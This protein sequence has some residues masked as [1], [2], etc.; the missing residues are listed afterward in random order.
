MSCSVSENSYY[1]TSII[2][3]KH[4]FSKK[5][6]FWLLFKKQNMHSFIV[7]SFK[8]QSVKGNDVA[9]NREISMFIK[10]NG[11]DLFV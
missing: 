8:S 2:N 5:K 7:A 9:C 1:S 3:G 6:C 4:E 10:H 11:V